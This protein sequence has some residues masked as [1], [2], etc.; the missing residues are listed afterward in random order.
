MKKIWALCLSM[1][2]G[3][4]VIAG[5]GSEEKQTVSTSSNDKPI[6]IGLV[7]RLNLKAVV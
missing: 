3:A 7:K 5:C 4:M 2:L 6:V 1:I